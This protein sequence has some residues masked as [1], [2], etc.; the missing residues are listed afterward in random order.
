MRDEHNHEL[1]ASV[2]KIINDIRMVNVTELRFTSNEIDDGIFKHFSQCL[3]TLNKLKILEISYND[4]GDETL[5]ELASILNENK[6]LEEINLSNNKLGNSGSD[7]S[8]TSFLESFLLELK[9]P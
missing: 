4:V 8:L 6:N 2:F 7:R 1:A 5:N 3:S 9:D